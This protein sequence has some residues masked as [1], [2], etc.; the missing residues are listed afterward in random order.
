MYSIDCNA[1][2]LVSKIKSKGAG[3]IEISTYDL[4]SM[5]TTSAFVTLYCSVILAIAVIY[6]LVFWFKYS[7]V[8]RS[9]SAA[10]FAIRATPKDKLEFP[11]YYYELQGWMNDNKHLK[12]SWREFEETLLLPGEDFD[13]GREVI[14]NTHLPSRYFNQSNLLFPNVN[15]RF[16]NALPNIL[17][18][19][20]I[21]GT[22]IGLTVG[23]YLAA[24]GLNSQHIDD[25]KNAL[26]ILLNG[27]SLA[28]I[29]S[30]VG[31]FTSLFFSAYEKRYVHRFNRACQRLNSELD[32]RVEYFSAERLASKNLAESQKQSIALQAFANDFAVSLGQIIEEKVSAPIVEAMDELRKDQKS[33][34]DE[35]I[36]KVMGEF[37]DKI[38][39][40]AGDEMQALASTIKIM[41]D[42]LESQVNALTKG[43]KDMQDT[44]QS[45]VTEMSNAMSDGS[46]RINDGIEQ[47]VNSLLSSV[48]ESV[49]NVT[50]QLDVASKK[51][52]THL[53][54]SLNGFHSVVLKLQET[55]THYQSMTDRNETLFRDI[56]QTIDDIADVT[57]KVSLANTSFK[58]TETTFLTYLTTLHEL[59]SKLGDS[60]D[61]IDSTLQHLK[62]VQ[63]EMALVWGSYEKRFDGLDST[64]T[65][66][67]ENIGSGLERYATQT[68]EYVLGLDKHASDVVQSLAAATQEISDAIENLGDSLERR[69]EVFETSVTSISLNAEN[70]LKQFRDKLGTASQTNTRPE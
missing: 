38:A 37:A 56:S 69:T 4:M 2:N 8:N 66:V 34:N 1:N 7:P 29:T 45:A 15:M 55:A 62:D 18:G 53:E 19:L 50:N 70:N 5:V 57:D 26:N 30:I 35:T 21:I 46:Q 47:A 14:M 48:Q 31:L 49:D 28:F 42:S 43:Q 20:G 6:G 12:D 10:L 32:A 64:L 59:S 51:L 24:P 11:P 63:N 36:T 68:D 22:F 58:E 33:A 17:T 16:Y 3:V 40:A 9:I 61:N 54:D 52:S 23:I 25:A 60:T 13:N 65:T 41:S 44:A 67:F 39:G 27:A